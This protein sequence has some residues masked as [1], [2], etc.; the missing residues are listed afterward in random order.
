MKKIEPIDERKIWHGTSNVQVI[1]KAIDKINELVDT[2]NEH[3]REL[4]RLHARITD[5]KYSMQEIVELVK[6]ME[7]MGG[8][9]RIVEVMNKLTGDEPCPECKGVGRIEHKHSPNPDLIGMVMLE[10]KTCNGSGV[11]EE[12]NPVNDQS[13]YVCTCGQEWDNHDP[14]KCVNKDA[15]KPKSDGLEDV[16]WGKQE[17]LAATRM[18]FAKEMVKDFAIAIRKFIKEEAPK[19][20]EYYGHPEFVKGYCAYRKELFTRLGIEEDV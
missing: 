15:P 2:A 6:T 16:I 18:D 1:C 9:K 20:T 5:K 14:E 3:S 4:I 12:K 11:K 10:C 19:M 13:A 17:Y 8:M 7:A